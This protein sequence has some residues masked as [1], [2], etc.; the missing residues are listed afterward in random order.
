M[1][2][3]IAGKTALVCAASKGLGRAC[4]MALASEGVAVTITG[5]SQDS[6]ATTAQEIAA[7]T[8]ITPSLAVGDIATDEGQRAALEVCPEPDILIN[9]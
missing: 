9:N 8:G 5:R 1:D 7:A 2:L 6:L 3:G 4:A